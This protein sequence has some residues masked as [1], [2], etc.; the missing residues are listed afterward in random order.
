MVLSVGM[1]GRTSGGAGQADHRV[2]SGFAPAAFRA[3]WATWR[4][5]RSE[6]AVAAFERAVSL[7]REALSLSFLGHVYARLG[8]RDEAVHLLRELEQLA[9]QNRASPIAFVVLYAGL[10]DTDAALQWVETACRSDAKYSIS[11]PVFPASI[12]FAR[13]HASPISSVASE[14][15]RLSRSSIR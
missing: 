9:A 12:R 2:L 5:G 7:S 6:E 11:P 10:G 3:R 8:R 1:P 13:T 15:C 4:Q 14:S